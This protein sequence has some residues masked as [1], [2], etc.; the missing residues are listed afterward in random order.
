MAVFGPPFFLM[1]V[2]ATLGLDL[3]CRVADVV[4]V[5]EPLLDRRSGNAATRRGAHHHGFAGCFWS[6]NGRAGGR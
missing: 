4:L 5:L 3:D 2:G 1:G 6:G